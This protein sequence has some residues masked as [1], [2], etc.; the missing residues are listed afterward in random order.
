MVPKSRLKLQSTHRTLLPCNAIEGHSRY[1][2][3]NTSQSPTFPPL[4]NLPAISC[5]G[6]EPCHTQRALRVA[7]LS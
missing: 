1:L 7:Q 2:Q 3:E 5:D 6:S 4:S